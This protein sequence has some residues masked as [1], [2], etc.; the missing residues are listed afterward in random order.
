MSHMIEFLLLA[1]LI[2]PGATPDL[3]MDDEPVRRRIAQSV[4][5]SDVKTISGRGD[6]EVSAEIVYDEAWR[7][8]KEMYYDQAFNGQNWDEWRHKYDGKLKTRASLNKA[9]EEMFASLGKNCPTV[10]ERVPVVLNGT[11]PPL[12]EP[13][14]L[15][16]ARTILDQPKESNAKMKD[17]AKMKDEPSSVMVKIRKDSQEMEITVPLAQSPGCC[18]RQARMIADHVGYVS[19]DGMISSNTGSLLKQAFSK[20]NNAHSVI[21]DLRNIPGGEIKAVA[22]VAG[23]FIGESAALSVIDRDGY[24][25]AVTPANRRFT[26][27]RLVLL[28]NDG[29]QGG[30]EIL[31]SALKE[32]KRAIIIGERSAAGTALVEQI[33]SLPDGTRVQIPTS[34]WVTSNDVDMDGKGIVPDVKVYVTAREIADGKG[35]WWQDANAT[36]V[37]DKKKLKDKQLLQAL[38]WLGS[39][40]RK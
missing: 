20:L 35:A 38:E 32:H 19:I 12:I 4:P 40:P 23:L 39:A 11:D 15:S 34:R 25:S 5:M 7:L 1:T 17:G 30:A 10:V 21:L 28:V 29:T 9:I 26:Q 3:L 14:A 24:K 33:V 36:A 37:P 27:Q 18:I 31:A 16:G 22:D 13:T 8:V 2:G 6:A